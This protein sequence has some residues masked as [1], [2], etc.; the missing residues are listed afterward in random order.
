LIFA[1]VESPGTAKSK[2]KATAGLNTH[3]QAF[4]RISGCIASLIIVSVGLPTIDWFIS[5]ALP[6]IG[7]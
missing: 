6:G 2:S 5:E 1:I 4:A 3:A 7:T